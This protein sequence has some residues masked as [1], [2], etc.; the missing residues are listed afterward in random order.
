VE[1]AKSLIKKKK[2]G[3]EERIET[4]REFLKNMKK[5]KNNQKI[6]F[7]LTFFMQLIGSISKN[8]SYSYYKRTG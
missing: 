6:I 3:E 2:R 4:K 7:H 1:S 8:Q 5:N